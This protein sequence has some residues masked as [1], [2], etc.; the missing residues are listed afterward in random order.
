[1]LSLSVIYLIDFVEVMCV[2]VEVIW[3]DGFYKIQTSG[4]YGSIV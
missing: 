3:L 4:L 2:G 1:V